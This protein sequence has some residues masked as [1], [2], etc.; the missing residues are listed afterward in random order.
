MESLNP[1]LTKQ[2]QETIF[3]RKTT[4]KIHPKIIFN[5]ILVTKDDSQNH[6]DLHLDSKLS[7]GIHMETMFTKVNRTIGLLRTFIIITQTIFDYHLQSFQKTT[8]RLWRCHL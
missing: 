7:F 5:N 3:S 6:L 2:A 8:L 4:K 1:D